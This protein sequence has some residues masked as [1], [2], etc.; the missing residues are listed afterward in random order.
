MA[1]VRFE[2]TDRHRRC[3]V[4][5]D[6]KPLLQLEVRKKR[7]LRTMNLTT[8]TLTQLDGKVLRTPVPTT[9]KMGTMFGPDDATLT[10]GSH[11]VSDELRD[12]RLSAKPVMSMYAPR[13]QS[14]LAAPA[15]T[16]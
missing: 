16:L 13:I 10:L 4:E 14:V 2:E 6:G 15:E 11:G 8:Q 7:S 9:G 5:A 3:I 1:D 12:M